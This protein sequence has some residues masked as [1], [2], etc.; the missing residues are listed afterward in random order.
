MQLNRSS[1]EKIMA[2]MGMSDMPLIQMRPSPAK[3][4][5]DWFAK[6]KNA[7]HAFMR[8]LADSVEELAL[9]SLSQDDFINLI[10]GRTMPANMSIRMRTPMAWGGEIIPEN[11][12]MCTTFPHSQDLD[13]FILGQ[14]GNEVIWMPNPAKKIY[15]PAHTAGGGDGGNATED[16]LSQIA[17]QIAADRGME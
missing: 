15:L 13:R 10:T 9:M 5:P 12:F 2:D 4:A 14:S 3:I 1:A 16:R 7:R 17:A 8:S 11:M 6:Y